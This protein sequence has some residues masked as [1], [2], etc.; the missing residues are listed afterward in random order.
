[1]TS[2]DR[3]LVGF[4]REV[5]VRPRSARFAASLLSP[6]LRTELIVPYIAERQ[7]VLYVIVYTPRK[8][9]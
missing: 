5:G 6:A 3:S 9:P 1:M 4:Q 8:G 7:S 2:L